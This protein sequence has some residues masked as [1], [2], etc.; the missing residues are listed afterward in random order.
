MVSDVWMLSQGRTQSLLPQ[1]F[2][3]INMMLDT[4]SQALHKAALWM[5]RN[6]SWLFQ[7]R[8]AFLKRFANIARDAES[9]SGL[10][11]KAAGSKISWTSAHIDSQLLKVGFLTALAPV[12][13]KINWQVFP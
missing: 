7:G 9:N 4:S 8:E 13:N 2:S 11:A 3:Q 6:M 12:Y 5:T 1:H 10:A